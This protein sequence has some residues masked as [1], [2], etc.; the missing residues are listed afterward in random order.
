MTHAI[1][2]YTL[3]QVFPKSAPC[4]SAG[5]T[6][7]NMLQLQER[8][9]FSHLFFTNLHMPLLAHCINNTPLNRSPAGTTDWYAHL[10]MA[11][12]TQ[13]LSLQ[14]SGVCCQF[15]PVDRGTLTYTKIKRKTDIEL[16]VDTFPEDLKAKSE[17]FSLKTVER[18]DWPTVAAVEV[19]WVIRIIL[20]HQWLL[21]NDGMALLADIFAQATS[22]LAVM[23][24]ATQVPE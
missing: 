6:N 2:H 18:W 8:T 22:F 13:E 7:G 9:G 15:F 17:L 12:Q 14:F 1:Q 24:W 23:T 4:S 11:G 5:H 21:F 16:T 19:V 3:Q 10:V 20:K